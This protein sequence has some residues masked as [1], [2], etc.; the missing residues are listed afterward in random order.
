[1]FSSR[2]G[3]IKQWVLFYLAT[4]NYWHGMFIFHSTFFIF[5]EIWL[6]T[7]LKNIHEW[8]TYSWLLCAQ[9]ASKA[10]RTNSN[11]KQQKKKDGVINKK[12]HLL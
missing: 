2:L 10:T 9:E 1:M 6:S 11:S 7:W 4:P 5:Y 3:V 12:F 8:K